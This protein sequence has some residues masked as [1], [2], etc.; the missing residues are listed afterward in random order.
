VRYSLEVI[1]IGKDFLNRT[2]AP[3]SAGNK[4]DLMKLKSFWTAKDTVIWTKWQPTEWDNLFIYLFFTNSTFDR[5]LIS[6][7]HKEL[8]KKKKTRYQ[9]NKPI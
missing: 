2:Q 9:E 6:K 1:G 3:R 8:K 4:W 7:I 5:G